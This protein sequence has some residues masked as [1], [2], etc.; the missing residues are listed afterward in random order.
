MRYQKTKLSP[1]PNWLCRKAL[2]FV[3]DTLDFDTDYAKNTVR[4]SYLLNLG[5]LREYA[6]DNHLDEMS[7]ILDIH[8]ILLK[9]EKAHEI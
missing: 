6:R 7:F 2:R 9:S 1:Y 5:I 8:D 4:E 3:F